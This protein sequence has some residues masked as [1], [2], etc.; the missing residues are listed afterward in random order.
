M[1]ATTQSIPLAQEVT[2]VYQVVKSILVF[3]FYAILDTK[4]LGVE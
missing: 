1:G 4:S 2:F 3:S